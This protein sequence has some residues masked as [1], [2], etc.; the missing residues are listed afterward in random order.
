MGN[1]TSTLTIALQDDLSGRANKAAGALRGLAA[2]G[3]G[4]KK[5]AAA[6]PQTAKLV[7]ELE[8]LQGLSGKL[9]LF[10][11]AAASA[12]HLGAKLREARTQ[13]QGAARDLQAAERRV[14]F[15]ARSKASGSSNYAGFAASGLVAEAEAKLRAAKAADAAARRR[16]G[17]TEGA[18]GEQKRAV[19]GLGASLGAAGINVKRLDAS[20]ASLRASIAFVNAEIA[21]QPALIAATVSGA[22]RLATASRDLAK[23]MG[24][25]GASQL[26]AIEHGRRLAD[27][28]SAQARAAR[29][30]RDEQSRLVQVEHQRKRASASGDLIAG[31]GSIGRRE[32]ERIAGGRRLSEGMSA[33]AREARAAAQASAEAAALRTKGQREARDLAAGVV[34]G[35]VGATMRAGYEKA[36][37]GWVEMDEASRRQKVILGLNDDQQKPLNAQALKIGQDTRF[38]NPDVV[39]AQTRI[40]SSLPEHLKDSGTIA[41]ITENA[42]NYALAMGTTMD[43]AS[44]AIL[45]RMLGLRMNMST[46]EAVAASS[47]ESANKLVQFAKSSGADHNDVMGYTK[48]GA[49]P[50]SVG[51]FSPEFADAMAAQLR[52]IGY[53]GAMAGNFVRAAATKLAVPTSKGLGALASAGINH[54]DYVKSGREMSPQNL[55]AALKQKFG[56][57]LNENQMARIHALMNDESV[58][59]NRE[60]FVP[61]V[62]AIVEESLARKT[63]KGAVN[64]TDAERIAKSVNEYLSAASGAVDIEK[65]MR[66]VL[67]KGITPALAKYLFGQEHGGRAQALD[68]KTLDKDQETFRNTPQDRAEKVGTEIN[69]GA[70]GAYQRMIGSVETFWMRLGQVND[71]PLTAFYDKV[72][73]A[74]DA[75]AS[76]PNGFLQAGTAVAGLAGAAI[77]ARGAFGMFRLAKDLLGFGGKAGLVASATALSGSAAAL[78]GAALA[79]S[80]AALGQAGKGVASAAATAAGGAATAAGGAAAGGVTVGGLV[81]GGALGAGAIAGAVLD[82]G[83]TR[84]GRAMDVPA[85]R[86]QRAREEAA[87]SGFGNGA[88]SGA[89]PRAAL[90]D[91]SSSG[92]SVAQ[93]K[94]SNGG[95]R[96]FLFGRPTETHALPAFGSGLKEMPTIKPQVDASALEGL[97]TTADATK[98]KL[99]QVGGTTVAPKG[100]TSG[101]DAIGAVLD[102]LIAKMGQL[103]ASVSGAKAQVAGISVPSG[104]G[105]GGGAKPSGVVRR[106]VQNNFA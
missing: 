96:D 29:H 80:R 68:L 20:E 65:M 4:L 99:D 90:P 87:G 18:Y 13:A 50:G 62:S 85:Y 94:G 61:Q 100:D 1:L 102:S 105:G 14:A 78:D 27:G 11:G 46:P 44:S 23:G 52:R 37:D 98:E 31:M 21:R 86:A 38:S 55:N 36:R 81:T 35:A 34:A 7:R 6:S 40:G 48:F 2:S 82:E 83:V 15:F 72:G 49:A 106:E 57:S 91:S 92:P 75:V 19:Q 43:E 58:V 88:F 8:R 93:W 51:G 101:L 60:E 84:M 33:Q 76:L 66:D 63:K 73:N 30:L 47:K 103:S 95:V 74:V 59:A 45:G 16:V 53:E 25:V 42:K 64:A 9:D 41:A 3:D 67:A 77:A 39:K 54:S 79:L 104:G 24:A 5:L 32:H 69:A 97:N 10:K 71:G 28:M 22:Q 26:S 70:Y 12:D 89:A 56:K 17:A